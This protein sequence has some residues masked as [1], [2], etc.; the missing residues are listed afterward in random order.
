[1]KYRVF[2]AGWDRLALERNLNAL[3]ERPEFEVITVLPPL[4]KQEYMIVTRA[5]EKT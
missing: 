5:K 1:M 4:H 3:G 2:L